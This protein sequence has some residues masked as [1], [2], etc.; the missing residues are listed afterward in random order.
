MMTA[1]PTPLLKES[2]DTHMRYM[3]IRTATTITA[4]TYDHSLW[5][6]AGKDGGP[7][8]YCINAKSPENA[9]NAYL[10]SLRVADRLNYYKSLQAL[11]EL[12]RDTPKLDGIRESKTLR[13][14]AILDA[15]IKCNGSVYA[16]AR[17]LDISAK[18]L[19]RWM[20]DS[21]IYT[22]NGDAI[23]NVK[24]KIEKE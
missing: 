8:I 23:N 4:I 1:K 15:L 5:L 10:D 2:P 20:R 9:L 12:G 17:E 24:D 13:K 22:G 19:Y 18:T 6:E 3:I 21:G 11:S 16:A 7:S 14:S